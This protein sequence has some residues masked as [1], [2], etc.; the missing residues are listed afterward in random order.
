MNAVV[1]GGGPAGMMLGLLLARAGVQVT[2]L[3]KHQDFLRDFRGDTVHPSTLEVLDDLGLSGRFDRLRY[4]KVTSLNVPLGGD[5]TP[6]E[7]FAGMRVKFPYIAFVPQWDFLDLLA[8]EARRHP[9]FT[10]HMSTPVTDVVERAGKIA[11]VRCADGREFH[12][13]LVVAADGRD[14]AVRRAAG[15]RVDELGAPIDVI[16]FR[17]TRHQD[18]QENLVFQ[19]ARGRGMVAIDRGDFWQ[20][21]YLI[22]KGGFDAWKAKG[23]EAFRRDVAQVAP[24]LADRTGELSSFESMGFLEVRVNRLRTWHRPGLLCIGDAAHAMSP[25]GGVGINLAVQDAVA[26]AN[27]LTRPLLDDSL[28]DNHL[29][30][31]QR[32]REW[33]TRLTQRVQAFLQRQG[34]DAKRKDGQLPVLMRFLVTRT[35]IPRRLAGRFLA[36]GFRPE[37]VRSV[38]T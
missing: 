35:G 2:V 8:E 13:D 28:T 12:A 7:A 37:R 16:W 24:M 22:G 38:T 27:I 4:R 5:L 1:V 32:R 34:F 36:F 11:G 31:V 14:S 21:G 23:I 3:E 17:L 19:L 33:P 15:M 20:C 10:L 6:I 9:T 26:T 30:A 25:V 18:D 29:A